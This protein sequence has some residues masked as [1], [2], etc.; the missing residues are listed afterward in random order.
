[1]TYKYDLTKAMLEIQ[2]EEDKRVFEI[3]EN[4]KC[5][6]ICGAITKSGETIYPHSKDDCDNE[7][8]KSVV[9]S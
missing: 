1:M 5:C 9:D 8:A 6:E 3:L 2:A 4:M 7:L